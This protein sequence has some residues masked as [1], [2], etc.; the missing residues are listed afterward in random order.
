MFASWAMITVAAFAAASDDEDAINGAFSLLRGNTLLHLR[1]SGTVTRANQTNS[2]Q[3]DAYFLQEAGPQGLAKIELI[4][5]LRD[6]GGTWHVINRVVGDGVNLYRYNFRTSEASSIQYGSPVGDI[7]QDYVARLFRSFA[8]IPSAIDA[9]F[10]R[11][12]KEIAGGNESTYRSWMPGHVA[13]V[14]PTGYVYAQ[15][16]PFERSVEFDLDEYGNLTGVRRRENRLVGN[17][18]NSVDWQ[19]EVLV[20]PS[21]YVPFVPYTRNDIPNWRL[22]TWFSAAGSGF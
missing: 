10:P 14:V 22:V 16:T 11:L 5:Q 13:K 20:S 6:A 9:Y 17:Q 15:I 3:A 12:V 1:L 2:V 21:T 4:E 7:P 18:I 19:V 8:T